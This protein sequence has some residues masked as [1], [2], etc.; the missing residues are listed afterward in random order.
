[1]VCLYIQGVKFEYT[2]KVLSSYKGRSRQ[3]RIS[4]KIVESV[5]SLML[6][7]AEIGQEDSRGDGTVASTYV[8]CHHVYMCPYL[9]DR[10][11]P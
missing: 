10:T 7:I 2:V 11:M 8:L 1:M 6:E 9:P 4:R 3:Q 5:W